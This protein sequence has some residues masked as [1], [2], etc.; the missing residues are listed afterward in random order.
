MLTSLNPFQRPDVET[1]VCIPSP[2]QGE[3]YHAIPFRGVK[4]SGC[5]LSPF[6]GG[7]AAGFRPE[8]ALG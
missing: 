7:N 3:K 2:F 1:S 8:R 4:T 5:I 6:Q